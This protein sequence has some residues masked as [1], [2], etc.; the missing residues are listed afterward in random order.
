[1]VETALQARFYQLLFLEALP[2]ELLE[3]TGLKALAAEVAFG[4]Y[5]WFNCLRNTPRRRAAATG[6]LA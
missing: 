1:V 2:L 6:S 5:T 4:S 3:T